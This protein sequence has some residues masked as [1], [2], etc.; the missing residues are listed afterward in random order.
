MWPAS[1]L[2]DVTKH[3][4]LHRFVWGVPV[5]RQRFGA[6]AC[7]PAIERFS[8]LVR[9]YTARAGEFRAPFDGAVECH[10]TTS[11]GARHGK[12]GWGA[13]GKV[14]VFGVVERNG[15]VRA[16]PIAGHSQAEVTPHIQPHTREGALHDTDEWQAHATLTLRA[17]H[18]V[19]R[20][21]KG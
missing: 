1:R 5:Y 9:A 11:G 8:R 12:R 14:I 4:L 6:L 20:K 15:Q 7:A 10:E 17:E 16:M 3:E 21:E 18:V 13:G 2:G 19:I